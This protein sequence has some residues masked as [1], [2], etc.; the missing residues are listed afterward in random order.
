M[1]LTIYDRNGRP[2]A[3]IA[4]GDEK[5]IYLWNGKPVAYLDGEHVYGFNSKHLGWFENGVMYDG[6][7][8]R[9]GFTQKTYPSITQVE[10]VKSKIC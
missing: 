9:I 5:I 8:R 1:E 4:Y 10:P 2:H 7:G 3:Y 6:Q